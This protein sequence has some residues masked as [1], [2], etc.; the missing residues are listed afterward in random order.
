MASFLTRATSFPS[1]PSTIPEYHDIMC[2][3][4]SFLIFKK[5]FS[6]IESYVTYN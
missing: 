6:F 5:F 3:H 4:S 1:F 2:R